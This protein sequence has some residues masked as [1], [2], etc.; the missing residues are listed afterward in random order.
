MH[1]FIKPLIFI[2]LIV[3]ETSQP[4]RNQHD[5]S[6]TSAHARRMKCRRSC[7]IAARGASNAACAYNAPEKQSTQCLVG[8]MLVILQ[9]QLN[10]ANLLLMYLLSC[11]SNCKDEPAIYGIHRFCV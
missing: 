1:Y 6:H 3:Q 8:V 2:H 11:M 4:K 9:I 5:L 10:K 7:R